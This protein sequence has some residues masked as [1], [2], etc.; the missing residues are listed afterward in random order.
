MSCREGVSHLCLLEC[1]CET[2]RENTLV[3]LRTRVCFEEG[4]S[5]SIINSSGFCTSRLPSSENAH[6]HTHICRKSAVHLDSS[7]GSY[8]GKGRQE[9]SGAC[10]DIRGPGRSSPSPQAQLILNVPT[11][12]LTVRQLQCADLRSHKHTC[13][14]PYTKPRTTC[15]HIH[16]V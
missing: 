4:F 10:W 14:H 13:A 15:L 8:P 9:S 16:K 2:Q 6:T 1:V 11:H 12:T 3:C 7:P 5:N